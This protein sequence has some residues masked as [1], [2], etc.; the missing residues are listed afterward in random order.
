MIALLWILAA[1]I[2]AAVIGLQ[3]CAIRNSRTRHPF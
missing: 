1:L 2:V 3:L